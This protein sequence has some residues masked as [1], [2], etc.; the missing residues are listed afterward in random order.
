MLN[1]KKYYEIIIRVDEKVEI[2]ADKSKS[3][4]ISRKYY[5]RILYWSIIK[6]D[7]NEREGISNIIRK[8]EREELQNHEENNQIDSV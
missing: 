8:V 2:R 1:E 6:E 3:T 7:D 4:S 5:K